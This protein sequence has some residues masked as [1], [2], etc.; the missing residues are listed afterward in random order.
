MLVCGTLPSQMQD[1][2]AGTHK[3]R[4]EDIQSETLKGCL[5]YFHIALGLGLVDD[6]FFPREMHKIC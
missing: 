3:S 6:D 1:C 5:H 4:A 2:G